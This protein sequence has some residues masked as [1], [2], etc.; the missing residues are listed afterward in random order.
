VEEVHRQQLHRG[1]EG[2][3]G[4]AGGRVDGLGR[5]MPLVVG[6]QMCRCA[7]VRVCGCAGESV[8]R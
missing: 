5:L 2:E 1:E 8:S 6:V 4:G 3:G 7:G